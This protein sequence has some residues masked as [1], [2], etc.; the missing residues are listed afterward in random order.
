MSTMSWKNASRNRVV[1]ANTYHVEINNIKEHKFSTGNEGF[2]FEYEIVG[3][4]NSGEVGGKI[5]DF[6]VLTEN[7]QWKLGWL[8]GACGVNTDAL[9]DMDTKYESFLR[10]LG[11]CKGRRMW[12]TVVKENYEGSDRNKVTDYLLDDDQEP[13]EHV[14]EV[15]DF[16]KN[17]MNKGK[18]EVPF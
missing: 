3:P 12:I 10:V 15:P 5:S 16:I 14:Q 13:I 1:P 6:L 9:P 17:K 4:E 18:E 7:T 11:L 8:V 2:I